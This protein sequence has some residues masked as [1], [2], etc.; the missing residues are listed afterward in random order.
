[1]QFLK[2]KTGENNVQLGGQI[3]PTGGESRAWIVLYERRASTHQALCVGKS[4]CFRRLE[5]L[6]AK[7]HT[8][9]TCDCGQQKTP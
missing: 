2:H 3:C 4:E 9:R 1:M 8:K 6:W 7:K 5:E